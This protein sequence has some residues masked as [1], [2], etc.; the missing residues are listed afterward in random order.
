MTKKIALITGASKGLGKALA[1]SLSKNYIVYSGVRDIRKAPKGT[2]PVHLDLTKEETLSKAVDHII[3]HHKKIDLLIHNAGVCYVGPVD[4]FTSEE[5][6]HQFQVNFFG[7]LALTQLILP[8]MRQEKSGKILFISSIRA[9]DSGPYIGVYSASKAALEATAFDWAIALTPWNISVSVFQPGPIN[10]GIEF[11]P[12]TH[13]KTSPY[14]QLK[15]FS[16][17][18]QSTQ[19]VCNAIL[20]HLNNPTP[21]FLA[22]SHPNTTEEA[23]KILN[24][25]SG[26]THFNAQKTWFQNHTN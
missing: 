5:T 13:F 22:Q 6:K 26:N 1:I 7:P 19:E 2:L 25:P 4:S 17:N 16:L 20:N 12:G 10:T 24:D 11:K 15:D 8:H 14:P 21:P 18:L 9:V 23:E 3:T